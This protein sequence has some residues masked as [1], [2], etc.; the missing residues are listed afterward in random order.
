[1]T[2]RSVRV[3][4]IAIGLLLAATLAWYAYSYLT[5][6]EPAP[7]DFDSLRAYEDVKTQVAF[8]PRAPGSEGHAKIRAW[9]RAELESAG[10]EVEVQVSER[11]G[12]PIYNLVA[13]R[14]DSN[15]PIILGAHYDTRLYADSDPEVANHTIP[16]LGANDGAS[17]VAVL[18][19]LARSLPND[20]TNVALVFFDAED[21]G[22]IEGWD[23]ILG[24]REFVEKIAYQPE[25]VV[26][27]DMIGDT[28]LNLFKER[29]SDPA[30]TDEIWAIADGLGYGG[31]FIPE[32]KHSMLDDHTPFLEAGIPAVDIIDFDYPYWHTVEDT[33][34]KVSAESLAA[35]GQTLWVWVVGQ[36]PQN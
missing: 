27:V 9:I 32:Y 18:L 17:G 34:D 29:N 26:I 5:Q 13:T 12:N 23:W 15:P 28:D 31:Q 24:S 10:W 33:P 21:N 35:V 2:Q 22:R 11:L 16:A 3:Y 14:G 36:N 25:A 8:G 1:M 30:L 7:T 20:V 4:L 6:P 19:E